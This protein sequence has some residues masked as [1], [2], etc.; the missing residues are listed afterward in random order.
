MGDWETRKIEGKKNSGQGLEQYQCIRDSDCRTRSGGDERADG[1]DCR[2]T[3]PEDCAICL[4]RTSVNG[5]VQGYCQCK[6]AERCSLCTIY[7]YY[8]FNGECVECPKN[9]GLI[10]VLFGV[11]IVGAI[12]GGKVLSHKRFNLAFIS[13]GVDYFQVLALFAYSK[14]KWPPLLK[15]L[16]MYFS[17]FNLN[18]DLTAPECLVPNLEY[19]HKWYAY[20][21][22]PIA[23]TFLLV[24]YVGAYFCYKRFCLRQTKKKVTCSH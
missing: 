14:I 21:A 6:P 24:V 3:N 17:I 1:A 13:I 4:N 11:A 15:Q 18:A 16:M 5:T 12:I 20:Q 7:E 2:Y 19:E 9:P 8:Q 23:V 10:F 22:L